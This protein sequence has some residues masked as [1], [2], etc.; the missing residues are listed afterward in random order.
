MSKKYNKNIAR[1]RESLGKVEEG[2]VEM[3]SAVCDANLGI[4]P[5][6]KIEQPSVSST[7][8]GLQK[9]QYIYGR[10]LEHG[11]MTM[12]QLL[13]VSDLSRTMCYDATTLLKEMGMVTVG[14]FSEKPKQFIFDVDKTKEIPKGW[15]S[16]VDLAHMK[17]PVSDKPRNG[18]PKASQPLDEDKIRNNPLTKMLMKTNEHP[19]QTTGYEQFMKDTNK[20]YGIKELD[21]VIKVLH[22]VCK[23]RIN[24]YIECPICKGRIQKN[25]TEVYCKKCK[26]RLDTGDFEKSLRMLESIA[27]AGVVN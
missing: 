7:P 18:T 13:E 26:I 12:N 5:E 11:P 8:Y 14:I 2:D 23:E 25:I 22:Q 15:P 20:F 24:R 17:A 6:K 16:K 19:I 27:K 9:A 21:E 4:T 10:F 3:I 1:I